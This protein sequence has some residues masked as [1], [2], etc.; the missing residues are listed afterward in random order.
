MPLS[1]TQYTY[2]WKNPAVQQVL[3]SAKPRPVELA[4]VKP[5]KPVKSAKPV[6][7]PVEPVVKTEVKKTFVPGSRL[8]NAMGRGPIFTGK[9]LALRPIPVPKNSN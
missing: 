6:T 5:V 2:Y 9:P 7:K 4:I 8:K 1:I 3:E